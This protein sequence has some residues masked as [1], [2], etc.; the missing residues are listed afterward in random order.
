MFPLQMY[1][2]L[3]ICKSTFHFSSLLMRLLLHNLDQVEISRMP[4]LSKARNFHLSYAITVYSFQPF[5]L[6]DF[7]T[8][9]TENCFPRIYSK[10]WNSQGTKNLLLCKS[11]VS[12]W[13]HEYVQVAQVTQMC[14]SFSTY[15]TYNILVN[16]FGRLYFQ[17]LVLSVRIS[18]VWRWFSAAYDHE[19]EIH[20]G[21]R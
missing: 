16:N 15:N 18:I 17:T 4:F 5:E 12:W 10:T 3:I 9:S 20:W 7:I 19:L 1:A 6:T 2:V 14:L 21:K 11:S 8:F 13:I